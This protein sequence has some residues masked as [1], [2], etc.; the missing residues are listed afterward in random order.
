MHPPNVGRSFQNPTS[1]T[2]VSGRIIKSTFWHRTGPKDVSVKAW[3]IE[4]VRDW[5]AGGTQNVLVH[6]RL[7]YSRRKDSG[8]SNGTGSALCQQTQATQES[9]GF[10][11][12]RIARRGEARRMDDLGA[13]PTSAVV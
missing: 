5:G 11:G 7:S 2:D 10:V 3:K 8:D 4:R 9:A 1:G 12:L 6:T 13:K